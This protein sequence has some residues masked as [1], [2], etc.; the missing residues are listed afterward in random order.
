MASDPNSPIG[1][2]FGAPCVLPRPIGC[3][4]MPT[5]HAAQIAALGA[6]YCT[7]FI[8]PNLS[9]FGSNQTASTK[10]QV[11]SPLPKEPIAQQTNTARGVAVLPFRAQS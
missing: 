1:G 3:A 9:P 11:D 5:K 8:G 10:L 7:G 4:A 2:E 6:P